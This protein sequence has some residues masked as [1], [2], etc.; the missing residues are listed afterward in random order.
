MAGLA[1]EVQFALH[2]VHQAL[3]M[4]FGILYF[5]VLHL[6]GA[7]YA[8]ALERELQQFGFLAALGH[9]EDHLVEKQR[10][11]RQQ[12]HYDLARKVMR[13]VVD[14]VLYG[15]C[16][17]LG[18][19]CLHA[20]AQL[21][22]MQRYD[23]AVAQAYEVA[24]YHVIVLQQRK[25]VAVDDLGAD[26]DRAALVILQRIEP[27][28][29]TLRRLELERRGRLLHVPFEIAAHGTQVAPQHLLHHIDQFVIL[30]LALRT[31][32]RALAVA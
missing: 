7:V 14:D 16:Q 1:V 2:G 13:D 17:H 10:R 4:A 8:R 20:G 32:A 23:R 5:E 15:H 19:R 3:G 25:D 22:R 18:L 12:R 27:L 6:L 28:F 11:R 21:D 26:D 30:G 29:E 9:R 31:D 24:V